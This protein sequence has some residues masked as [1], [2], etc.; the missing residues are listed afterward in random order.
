MS[1][2]SSKSQQLDHSPPEW[3]NGNGSNVDEDRN[4]DSTHNLELWLVDLI[5]GQK[6]EL[7]PSH[8]WLRLKLE[9][10]RHDE[11]SHKLAKLKHPWR[12]AI[13]EFMSSRNA[14]EAP[15]LAWKLRFIGLPRRVSKV[16]IFGHRRGDC[17]VRLVLCQQRNAKTG[18]AHSGSN[19]SDAFPPNQSD[20]ETLSRTNKSM[21]LTGSRAN[22]QLPR[23][24]S[25]MNDDRPQQ[26]SKRRVVSFTDGAESDTENGPSGIINI[27]S[28]VIDGEISRG[29]TLIPSDL[30]PTSALDQLSLPWLSIPEGVDDDARQMLKIPRALAHEQVEELRRITKSMIL[31]GESE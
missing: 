7:A 29:T 27:E 22:S 2:R 18:L 15:H 25:G 16:A 5:S 6:M 3:L 21:P 4:T 8:E 13:Q 1:R 10:A 24:V 19:I 9:K 17:L 12:T 11:V 28:E 23:M 14:N 31:D 26:P 30:V 20:P